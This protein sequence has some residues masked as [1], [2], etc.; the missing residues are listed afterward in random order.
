MVRR[1][2]LAILAV[3]TGLAGLPLPVAHAERVEELV[4]VAGAPSNQLVGYGLVVGIP[5]TGDQT[6]QVP[7]TQQAIT[8][9]LSHEGITLPQTAFMQ[10]NDVASVMVTATVPPYSEQGAA[11]NA[12]VSAVGNATSLAGGVLLPTPLTGGNGQIYA[13]AQGAILVSGFAAGAA[14]S[15]T[16]T[17]TPT[18]GQL[19]GGAIL[20]RSI[21]SS[22]SNNG[23]I[24]LLLNEPSF[25]NALKIADAINARYG[26][27]VASADS[28]GVVRLHD[29]GAT[30]SQSVIFMAGVMDIEV[31]PKQPLPIVVVDAQ[32]GTIVM[33][34]GVSLG[35]AVVSHGNLTVQIQVSN[36][37]SQPNPLA[38]GTTT[39]LRNA[40]VS[41]SEKPA[42]VVNL[43][44][45]TTLAQVAA[46]LNAIGAEPADLIAIIQALKEAGALK[47]EL[48]VV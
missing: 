44:K 28:P 7:Y 31:E 12:T 16:R 10:P 8:N 39:R 17:N 1:P 41:A 14:G 11:I 47:A 24:S 34:G 38:R 22:F 37:A 2:H 3:L 4:S 48:K 32:S 25:T 45:A 46:A 18:V 27:G 30:P 13:Q 35:P 15:S 21:P 20:S 6:T 36:T 23:Q 26:H 33:G 43:P 40:A 42:H 29:D 5:G 9:M 19:P